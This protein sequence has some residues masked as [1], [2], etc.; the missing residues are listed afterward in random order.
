MRIACSLASLVLMSALPAAQSLVRSN[1]ILGSSLDYQLAGDPLESFVLV[2]SLDDGPT[3]L[4]FLGGDPRSMAVSPDLRPYWR[5]G[6]LDAGG[7]AAV[8]FPLPPDP[9][10]IGLTVHAQFATFPGVPYF[11]DDISNPVAV[12]LAALGSSVLTSGELD[13]ALSGFAGVVLGDGR[14][15]I[16]G[17]GLR[18]SVGPVLFDDGLRYFDPQT[19]SFSEAPVS[20]AVPRVNH[21][22]TLLPDGRVLIVGGMIDWLGSEYEIT[23]S[24]QIYDPATDQLESVEPLPEPRAVHSATLL[25]NGKVLVVGGFA[26]FDVSNPFLLSGLLSSTLLFDP[27]SSSWQDGPSLP[28]GRYG[29]GVSVLLSGQV[30]VAGG[31]EN[32]YPF[33]AA[34]CLRYSPAS[35]TFQPAA[36]LPAARAFHGQVRLPGGRVL[37]AGGLDGLATTVGTCWLYDGAADSWS[38]ADSLAEPRFGHQVLIAGTKLVAIGGLVGTAGSPVT[39]IDTSASAPVDWHPTGT[40]LVGRSGQS[41]VIDGGQRVLTIGPEVDSTT[42]TTAEIFVP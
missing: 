6:R 40:M 30:L 22:A 41:F 28:A 19:E 8:T 15:L 1:G 9:T 16:T 14:V 5:H 11:V 24:A 31:V 37:V 20:M 23:D 17:G 18:D 3:P 21:T 4:R 10:L 29:H 42:D 13:R 39:S 7:H 27:A 36:A 35:N 32:V 2:P 33:Y 38:T 12:A 25:S 34:S 26:E